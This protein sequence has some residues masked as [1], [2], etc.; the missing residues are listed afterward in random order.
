[1]LSKEYRGIK[2]NKMEKLKKRKSFTAQCSKCGWKGSKYKVLV[3]FD[4]YH[5]PN[6][7][8]MNIKDS[9]NNPLSEY[10]K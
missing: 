2:T 10:S 1:M 8:S 7:S 6:C 9:K 3:S 5:C 4:G